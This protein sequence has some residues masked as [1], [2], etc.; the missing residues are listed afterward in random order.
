MMESTT[1]NT[2]IHSARCR[3]YCRQSVGTQVGPSM[4]KR[5]GKKVKLY[6]RLTCKCM[7][8]MGTYTC[9]EEHQQTHQRPTSRRN[10]GGPWAMGGI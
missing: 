7:Q 8:N 1:R 4:A 5:A 6:T 3:K 10:T 2:L 9:T